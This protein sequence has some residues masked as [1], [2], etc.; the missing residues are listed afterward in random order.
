MHIPLWPLYAGLI[1]SSVFFIFD[2][3]NTFYLRLCGAAS[4]FVLF[5]ICRIVSRG[6]LGLGD[7]QYALYCG[8]VTGF[9]S[10]FY[11]ILASCVLCGVVLFIKYRFLKKE[12]IYFTP[13][14]FVG[15]IFVVFLL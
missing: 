5:F 7:L 12:R 4:L 3:L 14:M 1:L 6:K 11:S 9:P 10:C 13:F 2:D 15:S 8:L